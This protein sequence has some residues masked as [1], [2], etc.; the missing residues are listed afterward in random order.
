MGTKKLILVPMGTKVPKWGPTW[1]QCNYHKRFHQQVIK[2]PVAGRLS[3][4]EAVDW[5]APVSNIDQHHQHNHC[6]DYVQDDH[7][8]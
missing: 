6:D 1:E 7:D 8:H 3:L 5:P 4:V 2:T